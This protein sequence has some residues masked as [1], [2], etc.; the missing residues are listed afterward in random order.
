MLKIGLQLYTL[1]EELEQDFEGTI[2]KVAELGYAGVEFFH[3]FG[4]TAEQ[5]N[6]LLQETGLT[7]LGAH[8]P[9]D[10]MLN[11]TEQEISFN[12]SIGNRNLIV[13]YLTEE[14]R[15]WEEVAVNLRKIGE[16]CSARG[17]VLSYHNHDFEFKEQFGGRTAFDGIFEEVPADLLQVEMDTCWVYY[18]GYDPVEYI[19]KY[20]GRLPIIHLKDMKKREDGSAETVVLGEGEVKLEAILEA[21]DAAGAE[22]AVVEQDFCSRSPLESVADS[23]KWI[24]AYANQGGKVHV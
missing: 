18:A 23:M 19:H 3:Y 7:A 13:P 24:R 1:R 9:Y 4:R 16:Q 14:Q 15:N 2:R 21:A 22:W 11:D 8:R 10:A 12:L 17:A 20:A 5:V 6:A